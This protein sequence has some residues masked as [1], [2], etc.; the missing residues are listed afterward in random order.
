MKIQPY[1]FKYP[2]PTMKH[3]LFAILTFVMALT[4]TKVTVY[5]FYSD[6]PQIGAPGTISLVIDT[7]RSGIEQSAAKRFDA[8]TAI[9]TP[10]SLKLEDA[11]AVLISSEL[12][13][14]SGKEITIK[15][16]N[17]KDIV[18]TLDIKG[19]MMRDLLRFIADNYIDAV[20]QISGYDFHALD[21]ERKTLF[22]SRE[23]VFSF[24][25]TEVPISEV[26][27]IVQSVSSNKIRLDEGD[28]SKKITLSVEKTTVREL[29]KQLSEQTGSK[30][31]VEN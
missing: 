2:L 25:A 14:Q 23:I 16:K 21:N 29:I 24:T 26:V 11:T 13:R 27:Q 15:P 12:T 28:G 7:K 9:N 31:V 19:V 5:F 17:A 1:R 6:G 3:I 10:I 4:I 8:I 30:L 22:E 18:V 20:I